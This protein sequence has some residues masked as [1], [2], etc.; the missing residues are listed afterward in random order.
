MRIPIDRM[1]QVQRLSQELAIGAISRLDAI[2]EIWGVDRVGAEAKIIEMDGAE[3]ET[4]ETVDPMTALNGAQVTSM[5]QIV[6]QVAL[7]QLPRDSAVEMITASFPLDKEQADRIVG[8]AGAGFVPAT[9]NDTNPDPATD[10]GDQ[11]SDTEDG[12]E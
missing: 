11:T 8:E 9:E 10:T 12:E 6:T 5:V 2:M 7:G 3:E 4:D 1:A